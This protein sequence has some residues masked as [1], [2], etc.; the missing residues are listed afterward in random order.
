VGPQ[1]SA[2][3]FPGKKTFKDTP[4]HFSKI[5]EHPSQKDSISHLSLPHSLIVIPKGRRRDDGK[6]P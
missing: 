4:S 1:G 3:L 2:S 6:R 5:E